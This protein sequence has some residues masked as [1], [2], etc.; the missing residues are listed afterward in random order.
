[1]QAEIKRL[2]ELCDLIGL[3]D[4]ILE[5]TDSGAKHTRG[6][7]WQFTR[8]YLAEY[9]TETQPGD[10]IALLKQVGAYNDGEAAMWVVEHEE[11]IP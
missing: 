7:E 2:S 10:V 1:M 3:A 11:E 9:A 4:Y 5:L 6:D 8:Q